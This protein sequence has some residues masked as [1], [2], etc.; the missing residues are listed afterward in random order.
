MGLTLEKQRKLAHVARRYYLE[1]WKQSDIAQELGVSRPLISR[2][3]REARELG[4]VEI[5]IHEPGAKTA[6][7]LERLRRS[8]AIQ[9]GVLVED[10]EDGD[11]TNQLLSQGA[12]DLLRQIGARRL[13][14]GWGYLIGQLVTWLEENPQPNSTVTDICPLVGNASIPARNYQ[15]NENVRVMAQQLGATPHFLYLPALPDNLEE[16]HLLCS[17]EVYRQIYQ[18]WEQIDTALVNI[19]DYPSSPDFASLV[20]YGSLL[21]QQHACGRMLV[22]YFNEEGTVIQSDQDFAIQVP[23]DTLKR[24]PNIIGVC[25]ANTSVKA[26]HGALRS[27]IFTHIVARA[28]LVQTLFD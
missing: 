24:C 27:G 23:I 18:Q 5:M 10:G 15:S 28:A 26:L 21:Q 13:G 2:M 8:N 19:G 22:Y 11:A 25:S 9:G 17:T 4:V 6:N 7:L 3:L 12:V 20:R 1:D 16:K 14:V